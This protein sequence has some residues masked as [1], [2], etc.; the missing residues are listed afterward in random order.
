MMD[1]L[2]EGEMVWIDIE[3][4]NLDSFIPEEGIMPATIIHYE[5][6]RD[7]RV[8]FFENIEGF[9]DNQLYVNPSGI[10]GKIKNNCVNCETPLL[11]HQ[12][13]DDWLCPFCDIEQHNSY[14][15][16]IWSWIKRRLIR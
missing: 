6:L 13:Y 14:H 3:M 15:E 7:V 2:K 10:T 1:G 8:E 9:E 11:F 16:K 4:G 5:G 12:R